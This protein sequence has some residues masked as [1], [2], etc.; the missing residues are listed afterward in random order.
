M[1]IRS[2]GLPA[3]LS[4]IVWDE[5]YLAFRRKA[6]VIVIERGGFGVDGMGKAHST[7]KSTIELIATTM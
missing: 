6:W 2:F 5:R 1:T 3:S 7:P 4:V